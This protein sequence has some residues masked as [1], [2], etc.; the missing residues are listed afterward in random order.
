M[1][2]LNV[3]RKELIE[4]TSQENSRKLLT[5]LSEI[6]LLKNVKNYDEI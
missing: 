6:K 5:E 4:T 3:I 2:E 1:I